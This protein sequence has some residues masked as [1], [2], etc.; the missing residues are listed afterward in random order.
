M[1]AIA[2]R[3]ENILNIRDG[4]SKKINRNSGKAVPALIDETDTYP[5]IKRIK[6]KTPAQ[7]RV[8]TGF[9]A[10]RT[11]VIVATPFPPLKPAKTGKI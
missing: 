3:S 7:E 10:S 5:V 9:M 11:P 4:V 1:R 2:T 6:T 8:S